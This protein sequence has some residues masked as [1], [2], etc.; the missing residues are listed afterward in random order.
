MMVR[1]VAGRVSSARVVAIRVVLRAAARARAA[2]DVVVL[3]VEFVVA[4]PGMGLFRI[5]VG[6]VGL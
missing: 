2:V 1:L 5:V 4:S 3:A 6:C